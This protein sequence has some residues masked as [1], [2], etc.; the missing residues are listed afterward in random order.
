DETIAERSGIDDIAATGEAHDQEEHTDDCSGQDEADG[1]FGEDAEAHGGVEGEDG[2]EM[3]GEVAVG[4]NWIWWRIE[5]CG[6]ET[7]AEGTADVNR[8]GE[9]GAEDEER[10]G[11][12]GA[13]GNDEHQAGGQRDGGPNARFWT[14][15]T[16][17]HAVGAN[18]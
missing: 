17:A 12:S 14:E 18:N 10:V 4:D 9:C 13:A 16:T 6:L 15:Q 1:A 11:C 7:R 2:G 8:E 3:L 5:G